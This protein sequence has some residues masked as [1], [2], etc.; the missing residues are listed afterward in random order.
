[1]KLVVSKN[2]S[3]TE[4]VFVEM[5]LSEFYDFLHEMEKAKHKMDS[6]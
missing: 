1:M 5:T 4:T 3:N 6:L 2:T